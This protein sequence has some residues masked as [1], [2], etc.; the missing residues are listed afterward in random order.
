MELDQEWA[1]VWAKSGKCPTWPGLWINVATSSG[2]G[3]DSGPPAGCSC[4]AQVWSQLQRQKPQ[5]GDPQLV[6]FFPGTY[7]HLAQ[8]L[9]TTLRLQCFGV[10]RMMSGLDRHG[11]ELPKPPTSGKKH[12]S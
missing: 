10:A 1:V 2:N 12:M 8:P 5:S 3:D 4:S 7:M 9:V 6:H 11:I